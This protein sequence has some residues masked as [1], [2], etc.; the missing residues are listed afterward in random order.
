MN[1]NEISKAFDDDHTTLCDTPSLK[2][3]NYRVANSHGGAG[4]G[5]T[6]KGY[7]CADKSNPNAVVNFS[8]FTIVYQKAIPSADYS[9]N[10]SNSDIF[11]RS[12]MMTIVTLLPNRVYL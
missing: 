3:E 4:A 12:N 5:H 9:N 7:D 2:D 6:Y 1:I 10:S 8:S 11:K